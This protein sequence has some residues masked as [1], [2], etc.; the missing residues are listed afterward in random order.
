MQDMESD[1][2]REIA[3][4]KLGRMYA[5][6]TGVTCRRKAILDYFGQQFDKP[7][8]GACDVCMGAL[9]SMD[10]PLETAQKIIS[11]VLRLEQRFGADYTAMVLTGSKEQRVLANGHDELSTYG[12]LREHGKRVVRDWVEQLVAQGLLAKVGEYDVL[13]VPASGVRLLKGHGRPPRLTKPPARKAASKA[14][15][16]EARSWEGVDHGLFE[17]LRD[18][19]A[20][21][22]AERHA[23]AYVVFGDAA[24]RDMARRKPTTPEQFL[25]VHGV[26]ETKRE[27]YADVFL[28]VIK[29]Y[30]R[31]AREA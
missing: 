18:L 22:A 2:A 3:L 6:C 16:V 9:E 24:L 5:Y 25:Q 17:V 19:R 11:C 20:R 27:Q 7:D 14:S 12:L 8:C 30:V 28:P 23:P 29:E 26:G 31:S 15:L 4:A 1:E 13:T 21:I 10:D